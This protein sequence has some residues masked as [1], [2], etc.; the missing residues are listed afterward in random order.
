MY[1]VTTPSRKTHL[2]HWLHYRLNSRRILSQPSNIDLHTSRIV[3]A[4]ELDEVE[5]L[6]GAL[7][8]M[9]Y[10]CWY[11]VPFFGQRILQQVEHKLNAKTLAGFQRCV[12]SVDY[13]FSISELA[14]RWSVLVMPSMHAYQHQL[15]ISID[16]SRAVAH[17]TI[18]ILLDLLE[19]LEEGADEDEIQA[20]IKAVEQEFF[21]HCVTCDD[22][23]AFFIVWWELAKKKWAFHE[24]WRVCRQRFEKQP[25]INEQMQLPSSDHQALPTAKSFDSVQA[26]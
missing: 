7:T 12:D 18:A 20:E 6:Q 14:T 5:P 25:L 4:L 23:M 11:D 15:R 26:Q 3:T 2:K 17:Q 22:R 8:D 13:M 21:T 24:G 19:E 1:S 10:G 9:F 16:D